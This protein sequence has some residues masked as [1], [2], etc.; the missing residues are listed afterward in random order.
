MI[1]K[2]I[3]AARN[4]LEPIHPLAR[5]VVSEAKALGIKVSK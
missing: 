2:S 5:E 1:E 4:K 3:L